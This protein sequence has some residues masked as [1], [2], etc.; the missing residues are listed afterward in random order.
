MEEI[1]SSSHDMAEDVGSDGKLLEEQDCLVETIIGESGLV[2]LLI[3]AYIKMT[4]H[5]FKRIKNQESKPS[6]SILAFLQ[7][8]KPSFLDS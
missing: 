5:H 8:H 4:Q 3:N 7:F 6:K 1:F 2:Q